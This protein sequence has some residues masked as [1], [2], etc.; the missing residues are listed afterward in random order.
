MAGIDPVVMPLPANL[1]FVTGRDVSD[2][3]QTVGLDRIPGA[4]PSRGANLLT[5]PTLDL[6]EPQERKI[7]LDDWLQQIARSMLG[8]AVWKPCS[9][10]ITKS[11][12]RAKSAIF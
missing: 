9:P 11:T 1:D 3:L 6:A 2:L 4:G 8:S 7:Q 12:P 5:N 10:P